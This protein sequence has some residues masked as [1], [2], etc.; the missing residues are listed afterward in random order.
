MAFTE[1]S[2]F[3][4]FWAAI[5]HRIKHHNRPTYHP[6]CRVWVSRQNKTCKATHNKKQA[7]GQALG[8][9]KAQQG[10]LKAQL[11]IHMNEN[12][13][14]P[15]IRLDAPCSA[16]ATPAALEQALEKIQTPPWQPS[17]SRPY[18]IHHTIPPHLKH[19]STPV[20]PH[21]APTQPDPELTAEQC[22]PKLGLETESSILKT[23]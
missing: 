11:M 19:Q 16:Q 14:G 15:P 4:D 9:L 5:A 3:E 23:A 6:C 20:S 22:P 10:D 12:Q 2:S 17:A 21:L 18:Y 7:W 13:W 1:F 8:T